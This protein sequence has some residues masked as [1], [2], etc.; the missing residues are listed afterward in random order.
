[1]SGHEEREILRLEAQVAALQAQ[2]KRAEQGE[3]LREALTVAAAARA[4]AEPVSHRRLLELVVETAAS[5]IRANAGALFLIDEEAQELTFE[6]ALG[7]SADEVRGLRIP[8]GHGIAG[9]VA[10]TAQPMAVSGGGEDE[11][12]ARDLQDQVGYRPETLLC[13]PLTLNDR[14][15]GVLELL[16]REDGQPFTPDDIDTLTLFAEQAAV[17]I[18]QSRNERAG[19]TLVAA[20]L[21]AEDDDLRRRLDEQLGELEDEPVFHRALELAQLV[22]DIVRHGQAELEAC[23]TILRG[24]ADYL[25][26]R[27]DPLAELG[28]FL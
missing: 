12:V 1:M 7:G 13:V 21:A 27:P 22:H 16:D 11:R 19:S 3:R 24:F 20:A 17:A 8:V 18:E 26:A 9:L 5:V 4:I 6:V 23:E 28:D 10:D 25:A 2:L 15:I 14:V